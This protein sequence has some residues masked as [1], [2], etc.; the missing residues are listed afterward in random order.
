MPPVAPQPAESLSQPAWQALA[1][2]HRDRARTW[3]APMRD[4]RAR[5]EAHPVFDFLNTYYQLS[6]GKLESWHAGLGVRLADGPAARRAFPARHYRFE[7]G[8]A[9][10][11]PRQ[12]TAKEGDRYRFILTLLRATQNRPPNFACHGLHEWAMVYRGLEVRH[13]ESVPLRLPQSEID[14]LVESRPL[15]CSHFDA[16]RFF[17]DDAKPRN[18]FR[19]DLWSR[20]DHEQPGCV[21]ANMDLYK[22]AAK[23][24][25]WVGSPLLLDCFQLALRAREVDMRASPYDLRVYGYE[26]IAIE[27]PEGRARYEHE[28][29]TLCDEA[30][31]LRE[32]LIT[33]LEN[34]LA[35]AGHEDHS[36]ADAAG[37]PSP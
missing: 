23:A 31:P 22:W 2:A 34:L 36:A 18:R 12:L 21:H 17:A 35:A 19:P 1:A 9:E 5:G 28:Q 29:R 25:P 11:A 14:A 32:R 6:L 15:C 4:R 26:P 16:Y 13:Q 3:T 30:R 20:E 10:L 7:D 33:A 8:W 24:M 37:V 27:T